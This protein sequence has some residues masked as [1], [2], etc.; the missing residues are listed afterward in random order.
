MR[1]MLRTV[2]RTGSEICPDQDLFLG[3][4]APF[5]LTMKQVLSLGFG[6]ALLAGSLYGLGHS[7]FLAEEI[8]IGVLSAACFSGV[9]GAYWLWA[10]LTGGYSNSP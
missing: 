7:L 10:D 1:P 2:N 5:L 6:A 3:P 9:L 8:P 4:G